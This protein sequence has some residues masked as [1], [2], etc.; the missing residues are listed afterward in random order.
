MFVL[1]QDL[2]VIL[3]N[4][5]TKSKKMKITQLCYASKRV[6]SEE[7]LL[8]EL[9][10]ILVKSRSNNEKNDICGVLY[11][12]KGYFF[13]CIQGEYENI[14]ALYNK[15]RKDDRHNQIKLVQHKSIQERCFYKWSMKYVNS[16]SE[17]NSFFENQGI[18]SFQPHEVSEKMIDEFLSIILNYVEAEPTGLAQGFMK[19]GYTGYF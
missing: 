8:E 13:Q 10:E 9:R 19:R 3:L 1:V 12:A 16:N 14:M 6:E 5:V 4:Y 17:L 18:C 15:I 7:N 11:Y 2:E